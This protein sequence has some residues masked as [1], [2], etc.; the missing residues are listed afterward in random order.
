MTSGR[1]TPGH[2]G[3]R[4][5]D[6]MM[7]GRTTRRFGGEVG[8]QS[9]RGE[10]HEGGDQ[11]LGRQ[12]FDDVIVVNVEERELRQHLHDVEQERDQVAA[13]DLGRALQLEEEIRILAQII[14]DM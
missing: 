7:R 3:R 10:S 2:V 5:N 11:S 9:L 4:T 13:R 1:M 6:N 12:V 14:D 8:N